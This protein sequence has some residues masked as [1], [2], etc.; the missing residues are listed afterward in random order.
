MMKS[1]KTLMVDSLKV[2]G[3]NKTNDSISVP[4]INLKQI[5]PV[6]VEKLAT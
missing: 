6:E 4:N 3:V 5:L 1:E 2:P